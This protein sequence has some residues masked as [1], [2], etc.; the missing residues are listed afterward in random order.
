MLLKIA[1][2]FFWIGNMPLYLFNLLKI[3]PKMFLK[4]APENL[5]KIAPLLSSELFTQLGAIFSTTR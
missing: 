5:L 4:I 3:A 2:S 1:L